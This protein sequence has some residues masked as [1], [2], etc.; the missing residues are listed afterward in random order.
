M[1]LSLC[2]LLLSSTAVPQAASPAIPPAVIPSAVPAHALAPEPA[3]SA[4]AVASAPSPIRLSA[5]AF[6]LSGEA[7]KIKTDDKVILHG[8]FFVPRKQTHRVPA[9]LLIHGAGRDRTQLA[10]VAE[11]LHKTGLAVLTID[12]R[13]HG[14]SATEESNWADY[15]DAKRAQQWA[16]AVRDLEAAVSWLKTRKEVHTSSLVLVGMGSGCTLAVKHATADLNVEALVLLAPPAK[17]LGFD[18]QEDVKELQGLATK[19]I[20]PKE[21]YTTAKTIIKIATDAN[22]GEEFIDITKSS[23]PTDSMLSDARVLRDISTWVRD[24]VLGTRGRGN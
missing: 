21:D 7:V 6:K 14:E 11:R 22:S 4:L 24:Q 19:I 5:S 17:E 23:K 10:E 9:A 13:G 3:T 18:L 2:T 1:L 8:D 12:L 20:S 15:D 16:L